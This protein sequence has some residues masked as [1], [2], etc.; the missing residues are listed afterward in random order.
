MTPEELEALGRRAKVA[1]WKWA[2]GQLVVP[3]DI[4]R[5]RLGPGIDRSGERYR[6]KD[7]DP[8]LVGGAGD[9]VYLKVHGECLDVATCY[10]DFSDIGTMGHLLAQVAI[11]D[12]QTHVGWMEMIGGELMDE[13]MANS[14]IEAL[15]A[16]P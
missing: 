12:P 5:N 7:C 6:V 14:L 4:I 9:G 1:G 2:G 13:G 8:C 10:P 11:A 3:G 16:A 15:E